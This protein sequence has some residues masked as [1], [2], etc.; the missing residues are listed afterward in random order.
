MNELTLRDK[1]FFASLLA[2]LQAVFG[3]DAESED[4][5]VP[6]A[7]GSKPRALAT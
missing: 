6:S 3:D 2:D 7:G 1:T 5:H 4:R